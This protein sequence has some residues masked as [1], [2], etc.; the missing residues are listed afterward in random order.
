[1][2]AER[3]PTVLPRLDPAAAL[4]VTAIHSVWIE[5]AVEP[6]VAGPPLDLM[7]HRAWLRPGLRAAWCLA[8]RVRT[9]DRTLT[10][11]ARRKAEQ[12]LLERVVAGPTMAAPG[13]LSDAPRVTPEMTTP[14]C[15]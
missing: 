10:G 9:A 11:D 4:E 8:T 13:R 3:L 1:M 6:E 2:L 7:T 12:L 5:L 14:A 15:A